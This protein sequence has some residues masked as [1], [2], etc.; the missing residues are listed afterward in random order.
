VLVNDPFFLPDRVLEYTP[1]GTLVQEIPVPY[2]VPGGIGGARGVVL[3]DAI[4]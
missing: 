4:P 3:I 1:D 2:P